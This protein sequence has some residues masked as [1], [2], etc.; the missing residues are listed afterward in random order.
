MNPPLESRSQAEPCCPSC[1][2]PRRSSIARIPPRPHTRLHRHRRTSRR[3]AIPRGS[4][5][6]SAAAGRQRCWIGLHAWMTRC[7]TTL[8]ENEG[9]ERRACGRYR[10]T[11]GDLS[12][13]VSTV[14]VLQWFP[15]TGT[16]E[17]PRIAPGH[18]ASRHPCYAYGANCT[19]AYTS[20][21][22]HT[23]STSAAPG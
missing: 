7:P 11:S 5:L 15:S 21:P 4:R 23:T 16:P 20:W 19:P 13:N 18:T 1:T 6:N 10:G 8:R 17:C 2:G 9:T 12:V 22:V 14:C 3:C